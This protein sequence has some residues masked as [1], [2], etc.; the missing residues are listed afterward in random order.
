MSDFDMIPVESSMLLEIGYDEPNS[1]LHVVFNGSYA[2][3]VY[4]GVSKDTFMSVL[5]A[6]SVG[7]A[8]NEMIRDQYGYDRL[9]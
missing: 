4:H 6:R 8:V 2:H 5:G 3:Y 9:D 7:R 1:D